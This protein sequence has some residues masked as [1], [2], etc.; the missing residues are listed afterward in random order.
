MLVQAAI[1]FA[2]RARASRSWLAAMRT[3][4]TLLVVALSGCSIGDMFNGRSAPQIEPQLPQVSPTAAKVALILPLTGQGE[5]ARIGVALKQAAELALFDA[6]DPDIELITKD[7][8]GTPQGAAAAA[9]AALAEG[10]EI[11]LGPLLASEVQAVSAVARQ[12]NVPVVA[13]STIGSV[14]GSGVYLL[15]F[16]LEEEVTQVVG[17]A[18]DN[19]G[20]RI[21][22]LLPDSPFGT[23]VERALASSAKAHGAGLVAVERYAATSQGLGDAANR[24]A[25]AVRDGAVEAVMIPDGG[26]ALRQ[27]GFA[28]QQAGVSPGQIRVLGTGA[29]D[30]ARIGTIPIA[31][32]GWFAGVPTELLSRFQ[33][34]YSKTYFSQ[35]PRIASLAYDAVSLAIILGRD[36]SVQRF[37]AAKITDQEGFQG[38][39]GLFRFRSNGLV[40]RGLAIL[41]VTPTGPRVIAP[42]P[43][44]F[45]AGF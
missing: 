41:E 5:T 10:A 45:G 23:T 8:G 37:S 16:L 11:I 36:T 15:S 26:E 18:A 9:S 21:A 17:Y 13:F 27:A 33:E 42:A 34:R 40:E 1:G 35:P 30:D 25:Q 22:A 24:I 28:L 19:G 20:R 14:A 43:Q 29:W 6:T 3:A 39:N 4:V 12:R 44:R 38:I 7:S 32:G 2:I 31:V